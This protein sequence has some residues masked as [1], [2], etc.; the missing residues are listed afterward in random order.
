MDALAEKGIRCSAIEEA[1]WGTVTKIQLPGGGTVGL[2][3]PTHPTAL[4][5]T[6]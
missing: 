5:P 1:R 2:Y 6:S 3:Q 4:A